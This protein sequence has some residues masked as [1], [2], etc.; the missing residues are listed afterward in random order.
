MISRTISGASFYCIKP[1][2]AVLC[3]ALLLLAKNG[4]LNHIQFE[5][6]IL[7]ESNN[8]TDRFGLYRN[9]KRLSTAYQPERSPELSGTLEREREYNSNL[10]RETGGWL[11]NKR[12]ISSIVDWVCPVGEPASV[13]SKSESDPVR[14]NAFRRPMINLE[15]KERE[16]TVSVQR[17]N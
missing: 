3:F 9:Q 12:T 8:L 2:K 17:T 14:E 13:D 10:C 1:Y 6:R 16:N 15:F 7:Y 5:A 11:P 4:K